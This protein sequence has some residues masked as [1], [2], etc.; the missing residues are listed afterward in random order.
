M[1]YGKYRLRCGGIYSNDY[2]EMVRYPTGGLDDV[3]AGNVTY[4][5]C[6]PAPKGVWS[7]DSGTGNHF[8]TSV[9]VKIASLLGINL[10]LD[11]NYSASHTLSY[12][13]TAAGKVCGDNAQPG[14]A[15]NVRS[16][17]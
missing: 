11:A 7:R 16:A 10:S 13:L 4:S 12:R 17:R 14:L 9:G 1:K 6:S 2:K 15:T 8:R 3:A 5:I